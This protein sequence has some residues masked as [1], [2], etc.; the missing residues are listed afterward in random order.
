MNEFSTNVNITEQ[1]NFIWKIANKLRGPY[2]PEKYKDVIIPMCVIRRFECVLEDTKEV[3][4]E[5]AKRIDIEAVLNSKSGYKFHNKS[6]FNLNKLLDDPDSIK[7]NFKSY[8][9]GFSSEVRD[10]IEKLHFDKEIDY[11][12]EKDRLYNVIKEF[13]QIDLHPQTVSNSEMGYIF[14]E[15]IRKFSENAEAGDHYTPREVIKLMV[16]IL[17]NEDSQDL[18]QDGKIVTV[19]DGTTGTGGM[20]AVASEYIKSLNSDTKIEVFGQEINDESYA[21]CKADMLI[22]GQDSKNIVLG[23]TLTDDGLKGIKVKYALMNPPFGVTWNDDFTKINEEHTTLGFNG[24]FGAGLPGK[25]DGALLFTQHMISKLEDDGRGAIIHNGS[26]L[27]S[28]KAESGESN[29]RKWLLE[30][31]LLEAIVALPTQM[32]YNTGIATYI[33]IIAKEK[34]QKRKGKVQLIDATNFGKRLRKGLGDKRNEITSEDIVTLTEIYD[35][36]KDSDVCK[37]LDNEDFL[38]RQITIDRPFSRNFAINKLRIENMTSQSAFSKLHDKDTYSE[39]VEKIKKTAKDKK[40]IEEFEKGKVLQ[41]TILNILNENISDTVYKNRDEF[42]KVI[43]DMFKDV[44]E[45]KAGLLK[46]IWMGLSEKDET[47][48]KYY[49]KKGE[50]EVD[51]ELRDTEIVPFKEDIYEYFE[52]EVKPHVADAIIDESKTKI[53]AEIPFTRLFYKYE[54][55][56]SYEEYITKAKELEAE[57]AKMLEEVF[58]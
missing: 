20:L 2:K 25:S 22:K 24:R 33:F 6:E 23:N 32:F 37:I 36:F 18:S 19:Y 17:L 54:D 26:P 35:E 49:D 48:H 44:A 55:E 56:G 30:E 8:L 47:A 34:E 27:F 50:V 45:V 4:L 53:G 57:I 52:R 51:S 12:D 31:D 40:A 29:I 5:Q 3:V 15:L 11:M 10:I 7:L 46:A 43:K 21:I 16:N 42:I 1:V 13:S 14:E 41:D 9:Q 39:L 28:G 58:E 38:Y